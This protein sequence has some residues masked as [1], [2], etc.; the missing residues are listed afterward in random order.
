MRL[1][2]RIGDC[3]VEILV[4][5][6]ST[7]NFLDPLVLR[8]AKLKVQREARLQVKLANGDTVL[9][10]GSCNDIINIQG[11][12]FTIPFHVLSLGDCDVVL[13]VQ[14][15]RTLGPI[16]WDFSTMSMSFC[17]GQSRVALQGV[18]NVDQWVQNGRGCINSSLVTQQGWFLTAYDRRTITTT[19]KSGC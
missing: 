10:K 12:R 17:F 19:W 14:W 1:L 15:L 16:N 7:H 6:G 9:N 13:G 18:K 2:G 11:S 5:S 3:S 8:A 4:D